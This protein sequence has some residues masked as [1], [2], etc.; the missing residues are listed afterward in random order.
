L[1]LEQYLW[2]AIQKAAQG[3][4]IDDYDAGQGGTGKI[5]WIACNFLSSGVPY[6][7]WSRDGRRAYVYRSS[8][9]DDFDGIAVRLGVGVEKA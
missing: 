8:P 1:T 9:G 2:Y 6:G 7:C 3:I 4:V 5:S